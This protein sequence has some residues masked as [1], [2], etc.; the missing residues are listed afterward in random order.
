M[1]DQPY[2]R[3]TILYAAVATGYYINGELTTIE[4]YR[5]VRERYQ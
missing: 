2:A 1:D 5:E 4:H 3:E